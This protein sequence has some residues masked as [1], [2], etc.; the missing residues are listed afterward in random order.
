MARTP[1]RTKPSRDLAGWVFLVVG[2]VLWGASFVFSLV[3]GLV[4]AVRRW[5]R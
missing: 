5:T 4:A 2:W 1:R 3:R